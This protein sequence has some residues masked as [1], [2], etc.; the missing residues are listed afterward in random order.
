MTTSA[1]S[2]RLLLGAAL[3]A[4]LALVAFGPLALWSDR[5]PDRIATHWG[6]SGPPD[7]SMTTNTFV[8]VMVAF[9]A[10]AVAG[11]IALAVRRRF[12][13]G[14][15]PT[16]AAIVAVTGGIIAAAAFMT[17]AANRDVTDWREASNPNIAVVIGVVLAGTA[18]GAAA[19]RLALAIDATDPPDSDTGSGAPPMLDIAPSEQVVWTAGAHARWVV[20]LDTSLVVLGVVL[21]AAGQS[22]AGVV[23]AGSGLLTSP[24]ASINVRAD[25]RG[26]RIA[27]GPLRWPVQRIRLDR[28]ERA[29]VI[30]VRPMEWGGWGYRGSVKLFKRAA[31][32]LRS[33]E[34]IQLSLHGGAR[35]AVTIDDAATG[36]A[37]LNGAIA[38]AR[39]HHE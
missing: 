29:D 23:L 2:L 12:S 35:F 21:V 9:L 28:I 30:E 17:F 18:L 25:R 14:I 16:F 34:G 38:R 5:L 22:F 20:A 15:R 33:G 13:R 24:L 39:D 10:P 4:V 27:Y 3:P 6:A 32:V 1:R 36:V 26:L 19:A 7:G 11:L 31:V 37:V 8:T